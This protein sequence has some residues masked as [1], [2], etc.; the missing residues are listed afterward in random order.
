[1][2]VVGVALAA[3]WARGS[4]GTR[5]ATLPAA[6]PAGIIGAVW[7]VRFA[8]VGIGMLNSLPL[9]GLDNGKVVE[10]LRP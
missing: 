5:F 2:V 7:F 10:L 4:T 8:S 9:F 6:V 1:L 3:S